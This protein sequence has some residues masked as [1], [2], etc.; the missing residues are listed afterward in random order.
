VTTPAATEQDFI[1]AWLDHAAGV[2]ALITGLATLFGVTVNS[3]IAVWTCSEA[4]RAR[5]QAERVAVIASDDQVHAVEQRKVLHEKFDELATSVDGKLSKY[6]DSVATAGIAKG[7]LAG[8]E[9]G[10]AE[11]ESIEEAVAKAVESG[12]AKA[13]ADKANPL[14]VQP[15]QGRRETDA[16]R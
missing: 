7:K 3:I 1:F 5:Q 6:V 15:G 4:R 10:R 2:G 8:I 12:I 9:E 13:V 11:H 16:K 14:S